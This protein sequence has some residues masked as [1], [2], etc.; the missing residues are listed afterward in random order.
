MLPAGEQLFRFNLVGSPFSGTQAK[1]PHH[2]LPQ[3]FTHLCSDV[4][5]E[6]PMR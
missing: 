1:E 6:F 4:N 3:S 2:C 5:A